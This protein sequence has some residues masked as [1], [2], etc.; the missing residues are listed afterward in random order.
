M[1]SIMTRA[2]AFAAG[3]ALLAGCSSTEASPTPQD[4]ASST[5][6]FPAKVTHASGETTVPTKPERIVVLDM[7]A[8]DTVDT[9]GAGERVVGTPTKSV[10][11]WLKDTDGIDYTKVTDV[12]TLI[13][14]DMEAIAKLKPDL[15]VVGG[16]TS[17]L[18][19]EFAK[20]FTTIDTSVSWDADSYS[21]RVP[22]SIK[23]IG[24]ATGDSEAATEAADKITATIDKYRDAG[25]GKGTAA[26]LMTNAGEISLHGVKSRWAPI[27]DVFG[28]EPAGDQKAD[29][30]HKGDKIS[31]ETVKELNPD[32]LFVV[33]R[34]AAVGTT[35]AGA[36]AAQV[37]D[38][39]LVKAT[40]A[41]KNDRIVYL[42]P[43]RWYIVMTGA[44]NFPT[45]LDEVNQAITERA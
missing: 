30:G 1:R 42:S 5:T 17:A 43:E 41:A 31:F 33:D 26:V 9:I 38:N 10:P 29:D 8:L 44:S 18:Y 2:A 35:E 24:D 39:D 3:L 20:H 34:D 40:N 11:T 14:P 16:R 6:G 37:L 45:M 23:M 4:P 22:D 32:W 25:K 12:G 36:T 28:F 13:E 27:F 19:P 7:A 21:E 15:V